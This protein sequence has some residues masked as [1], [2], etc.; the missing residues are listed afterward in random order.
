MVFFSL[1][2]SPLFLLQDQDRAILQL[3]VQKDR[4]HKYTIQIRLVI[5]R[6]VAIAKQ[7]LKQEKKPNA[8]LALKRKK[9]QE[10]LLDQT[11]RQMLNLEELVHSIQFAEMQKQVFDALKQGN[12][13]LSRLNQETS[14]EEVERLMDD[15][16]EAVEYQHQISELMGSQLN[17]EDEADVERTIA[18]WEEQEAQASAGKLPEAP[19]KKPHVVED[20]PIEDSPE[21]AAP[22]AAASSSKPVKAKRREVVLA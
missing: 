11:E 5:A 10:N 2:L 7:L 1:S 18:E 13:V 15:T 12:S 17:E 20:S 21:V 4:L 14:M 8:L 19:T 3:K 9:Y 16:R 6:E 22:A